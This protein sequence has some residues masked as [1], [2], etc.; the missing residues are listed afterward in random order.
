MRWF[1]LVLGVIA[2]LVGTVWTLQGLNILGGSVMSGQMIFVV[3]GPI[4]GV[5]GL[6]LVVLGLRR[7]AAG[8]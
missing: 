5:I 8:A 2:I 6:L 1:W 4:V 7:R 3:V